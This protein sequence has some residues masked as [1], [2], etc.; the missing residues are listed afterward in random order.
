[1][2]RARTQ[3]LLCE[4]EDNEL[5]ERILELVIAGTPIEA[6]RR[7]LLNKDNT[8]TLDNAIQLGRQ[9]E[10]ASRGT[11]H[12]E[13]MIIP[14]TQKVDHVKMK[15]KSCGNC[16]RQ[17][18]YR[19]CPAYESECH[20]CG[21]KG[22]WKDFCR[23]SQATAKHRASSSQHKT[24]RWNTK[25]NKRAAR[26]FHTIR[27]EISSSDSDT[28]QERSC[29]SF[30][31][32]TMDEMTRDKA[33]TMI[34]IQ[35]TNI[36]GPCNLRVKIDTGA[37]ANALPLR[38]F[39]QMYGEIEPQKILDKVGKTTLTAY[40]GNQ[41]KCLGSLKMKCQQ[42]DSNWIDT[43]FYVVDVPGPA[44]LGLPICQ[45]LGLVSINC[46]LVDQLTRNI[47]SVHDLKSQFPNQFDRIGKFSDAAKILLKAEAEPHIDRPRKYNINLLPKIK[48]EL[49]IMEQ[50]G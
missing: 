10:A 22:H 33:F 23:K 29:K 36:I 26:K 47:T 21:K 3:A 12:L 39:K 24:S 27:E 38:T 34:N 42:E 2:T 31:T 50:M 11:Q 30:Y 49:M 16:G 40:S 46:K 20:Y 32:I 48:E 35:A 5:E 1:M 14:Q 43:N 37:N 18:N 15:T 19:E 41:L 17:H 45:E 8:L 9:H 4:F 13:S 28:D 44:I 7:D 6:F 25:E